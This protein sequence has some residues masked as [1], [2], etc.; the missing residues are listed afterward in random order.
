MQLD[1]DHLDLHQISPN[2][3]TM[4]STLKGKEFAPK[5]SKFFPFGVDP[6]SGDGVIS[7]DYV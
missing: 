7:P 2:V 4:V 5:K 1:V 6:F 3:N